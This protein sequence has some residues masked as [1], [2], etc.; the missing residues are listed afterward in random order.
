[1]TAV[2]QIILL[3]ICYLPQCIVFMLLSYGSVFLPVS[4]LWHVLTSADV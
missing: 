2:D 1:M 3:L 4:L